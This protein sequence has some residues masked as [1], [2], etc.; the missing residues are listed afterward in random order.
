[1]VCI[2]RGPAT[3]RKRARIYILGLPFI[4]GGYAGICFSG[5]PAARDLFTGHRLRIKWCSAYCVERRFQPEIMPG[6]VFCIGNLRYDPVHPAL[7][8][9]DG[10]ADR[11][12]GPRI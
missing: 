8:R 9:S 12:K 10:V 4:R 1:M 6:S 5:K 2:T 3:R 11:L 7:L